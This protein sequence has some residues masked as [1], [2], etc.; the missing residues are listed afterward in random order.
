MS[1][2]IS[3]CLPSMSPR[4]TRR[5]RGAAGFVMRWRWLEPND[6]LQRQKSAELRWILHTPWPPAMHPNSMDVFALP[7]SAF[8]MSL[9]P[10]SARAAGTR[11]F[12]DAVAAFLESGFREMGVTGQVVTTPDTIQVTWAPPETDP[13]D[14]GIEMLRRGQTCEGCQRFDLLR[15]LTPIPGSSC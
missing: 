10:E 6:L 11:E 2:F 3:K 4:E 14:T 13:I 8:D 12:R 9:L 15:A 7:I 1:A 5:P